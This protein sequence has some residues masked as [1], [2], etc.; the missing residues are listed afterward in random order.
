MKSSNLSGNRSVSDLVAAVLH[1]ECHAQTAGDWQ[2]DEIPLFEGRRVG[3]FRAS[4]MRLI[5]KSRFCWP[6]T[7]IWIVL[8]GGPVGGSA[9][10]PAIFRSWDR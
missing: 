6:R 1:V 8:E 3:V 7:A 4:D 10:P 9:E 5:F 2:F